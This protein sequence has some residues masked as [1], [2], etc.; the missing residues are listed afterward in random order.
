MQLKSSRKRL[1][2]NAITHAMT[3]AGCVGLAALLPACGADSP[4]SGATSTNFDARA[5][6]IVAQMTLDEKIAQLHGIKDKENYRV[7]PGLAR[8]GI[9]ALTVANGPAGL[10]PAG[11]GHSGNATALPAPISLAATWDTDAARIDGEI[12]GNEAAALGNLLLESPDINIAR[13]PHNG[14]TFESF[15]EDPC[16]AGRLAIANIE[17]IQSQGVIANVKHYAGNNQELNRLSISDDVDERTLREIYLPAFEAAVK[18]GH[19]GSLMGAYNKV[20][21]AFCCENAFL[22]ND[23]LKGDW[24]FDGFVTSDFGAVHSTVP[25]AKNG[26]DLEMPTGIYFGQALKQ[27]VESNQVP[28]SL[29]DDKLVRR[30][31]TMMRFGEWDRPAAHGEIPASHAAAA[32]KLGAE[33]IVLLKNADGRLPLKTNAIHSIALIGPFAGQAMT[34]GGGS[35]HVSPMLTVTPVQG[36]QNAVGPDVKVYEDD[37][38]NVDRAVALATNA[39]LAVLMLGDRQTEGHDHPILLTTNQNDLAAAVLAAKPGTIVVLK[40]GGPVLMPWIDQVP[41]ILEAWYPGEEDG[42]AVANV[43]FGMINPSGKLPITF[44]KRDEDT[45]TQSAGQYPGVDKVAHYSEGMLVGY[46]WYD[47]KGIEPLFPFG[48]GLSYTTFSCRDLKVSASTAQK[49]ITVEFTVTNTGNRAGAE[50]AQLYLGLPSSPSVPEPPR[51]LKG[52][53]RLELGPG[54]SA[55]VKFAL[56]AR[57]LSYWDTPSRQWKVMPGDYTVSAGSSSRDLPLSGKFTIE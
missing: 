25:S 13:T 36:I 47:A 41:A 52:F 32:L 35:S 40:T 7:V 38:K 33:G 50:V 17:G 46:R 3:V 45:P 44:P 15:G 8:L 10:G 55:T 16:L 23:V 53:R 56:N 14:R 5:R 39:D 57:S 9:P 34:G 20:N 19:V 37:G 2:Y 12:A 18:E 24:G 43:L 28:V 11:P 21:G 49:D 6:Q 30:F 27:A 51:E 31:R 29:L 4:D 54:Q 1:N 26:L 48:Y 22:L 42:A